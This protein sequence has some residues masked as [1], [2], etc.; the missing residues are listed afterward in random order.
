MH[1]VTVK[2]AIKVD[3]FQTSNN[4]STEKQFTVAEN[5][6]VTVEPSKEH[7]F[8]MTTDE[9]AKG[10]GVAGNTIRTH[11]LAHQEELI[12]GKHFITVE[13]TKMNGVG[14][15]DSDRES[16][17]YKKTLWTKRGI[18]RLGFFIKSER[19]KLFRD[20]AEDLVIL[21][22]EQAEKAQQLSLWP[23]PEKRRHNRLT[24]ERLVDLLADVA[25][26]E[27]K[28]LR[29]SIVNKLINNH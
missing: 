19:A 13:N 27:D 8:L 6:I 21:I 12:E 24:Q 7:E 14:K 29:L 4:M 5:L 18:V 28:E 17:T 20:W 22:D 23:E 10:Y 15:T 11:K 1:R 26:I 9:V 16:A 2:H 25:K 3:N